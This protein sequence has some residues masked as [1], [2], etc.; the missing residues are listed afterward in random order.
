[1]LI[2]ARARA[3]DSSSPVEYSE[4]GIYVRGFISKPGFTRSNRRDQ[5]TIVN[6]RTANAE[7]I[8]FAIR[9]AYDTLIIKGRYPS[10]VLYI[11]LAADRVDV[12]VHPTKRE[13]RFRDAR[14]VSLII[15]TALRTALRTMP[16]GEDKATL[17]QL[18]PSQPVIAARQE[19]LKF[20]EPEPAPAPT[21][22]SVE[23]IQAPIV[24]AKDIQPALPSMIPP[25]P[26]VSPP[27]PPPPPAAPA[28]VETV[29]PA[30]PKDLVSMR[31]CGRFGKRYAL[32]ESA[33]GLVII[34][35]RAAHQRILFEKLLV[36]LKQK[37]VQQQQLLIPVTINLGH[38]EAK[39]LRSQLRHFE[40]LGFTVESFGGNSYL[41]TA[42]PAAYPNQD[43]AKAMRDIIDDLRQSRTT[44][45]Q[46]AVH[47]AQ[48]ACRHAI[49]LKDSVTEAEI[50]H[51]VNQLAHANALC[52]SQWESDHD[53]S[54]LC[55]T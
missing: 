41:V 21:P 6:G 45:V 46:S 22:M 23:T 3:F 27:P 38:E 55:R 26:S 44:Q 16:G 43:I 42:V 7:T 48:A 52:G 54:Y 28:P 25:A 18:T 50:A 14:Q 39:F 37:S 40:E 12:N 19:E 4:D 2:F 5:R 11:D 36:N 10:A 31:I 15:G 32:A 34:D 1:M 53:S 24:E 29:R 8:Y 13:V 47:L 51:I 33:H 20:D 30:P 49:S 17:P 9:E 35:I